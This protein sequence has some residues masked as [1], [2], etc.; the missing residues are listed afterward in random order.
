MIECEWICIK[1]N[2]KA[3]RYKIQLK[4]DNLILNV[5]GICLECFNPNEY[6]ILE[7]NLN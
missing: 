3:A 5:C 2:G 6:T 7:E 1:G 4:E